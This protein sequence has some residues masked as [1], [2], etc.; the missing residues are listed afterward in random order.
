M[1]SHVTDLKPGDFV[2]TIGDAHVYVNHVEALKE[3]FL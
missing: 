3:Q 2:H 1:I